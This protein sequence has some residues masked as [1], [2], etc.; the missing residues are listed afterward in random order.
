MSTTANRSNEQGGVVQERELH[1]M[2]K[3]P[4]DLNTHPNPPARSFTSP[5]ASSTA[6]LLL[7]PRQLFPTALAGVLICLQLQIPKCLVKRRAITSCKSDAFRKRCILISMG[8]GGDVHPDRVTA[9]AVAELGLGRAPG[10]TCYKPQY[11]GQTVPNS[12][13][14]LQ[15]SLRRRRRTPG[16]GPCCLGCSSAPEREG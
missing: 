3:C 6:A 12:A 11:P 9:R 5:S 2:R 1:D 10:Q 13:K 16:Q 15:Y 14:L 7:R 8:G 4:N